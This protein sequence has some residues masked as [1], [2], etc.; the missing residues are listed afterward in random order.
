[1]KII[2][3]EITLNN[4][5]VW[6]IDWDDYQ[7]KIKELEKLEKDIKDVLIDGIG[8]GRGNIDVSCSMDI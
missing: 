8:V 3:V 5:Q 1:M 4:V 7:S 6:D 2:T